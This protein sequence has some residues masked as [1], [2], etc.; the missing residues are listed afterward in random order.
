MTYTLTLSTSTAQGSLVLS[1]EGEAVQGR[2]WLKEKSHSEKVT[3]ELQDLFKTAKLEFKDL[4]LLICTQ[5]P[6]SF[7]G[8]RVGLSV[9]K[10]L[11]YAYKLPIIAIDDC[12]AIAFNG[13]TSQLPIAVMIDAQKNKVFLATYKWNGKLEVI[14]PPTLVG[15]DEIEKY[16]P[17][18][19]YLC[20]GD[21]FSQFN[22]FLPKTLLEK[23]IRDSGISDLPLAETIFN[24]VFPLK[25]DFAKINWENLQPLYLRES[26]AEEVLAAKQK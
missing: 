13:K 9:V 12:M 16:L 15:L 11:A 7:T 5:G 2:T 25:N 20:L 1:R 10:T 14:T 4:N 17:Q 19:Q 24:Q 22:K 3:L 6:G 21:G 26:A 18:F 8:I 23:L